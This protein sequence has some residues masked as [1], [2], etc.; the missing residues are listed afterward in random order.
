MK[1]TTTFFLAI[2]SLLLASCNKEKASPAKQ[3]DSMPGMSAEE[4][5]K[6]KK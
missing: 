1:T 6:M 4:H 3:Q 5:E 2:A